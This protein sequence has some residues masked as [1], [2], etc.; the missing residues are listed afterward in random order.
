MRC[1]CY[2]ASMASPRVVPLA[3]HIGLKILKSLHQRCTL[4]QLHDIGLAT[5]FFP[6][7]EQHLSYTERRRHFQRYRTLSSCRL[8]VEL[9]AVLLETPIECCAGAGE[10]RMWLLSPGGSVWFHH[11]EERSMAEAW[12]SWCAPRCT[13][14]CPCRCPRALS[15]CACVLRKTRTRRDMVVARSNL[16]WQRSK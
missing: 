4:C 13:L 10:Q 8:A 6:E 9:G 11:P 3:H 15:L 1:S 2:R 16:E 12:S 5:P 14:P 7:T